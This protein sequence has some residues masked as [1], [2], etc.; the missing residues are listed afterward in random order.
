VSSGIAAVSG[1]MLAA[2]V[3]M[4]G[5]SADPAMAQLLASSYAAY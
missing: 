2:A 3:S 1:V 5:M 4:A